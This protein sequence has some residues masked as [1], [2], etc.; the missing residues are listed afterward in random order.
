MVCWLV[1]EFYWFV[2]SF[3]F[4]A[5]FGFWC[6]GFCFGLGLCLVGSWRCLDFGIFGVVVFVLVRLCFYCLVCVMVYLGLCWF[7]LGWLVYRLTM[8]GWLCWLM[9]GV[10]LEYLAVGWVLDW[11]CG[12][13]LTCCAI[14]CFIV[15]FVTWCLLDLCFCLYIGCLRVCCCYSVLLFA[16][17]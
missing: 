2:L 8:F 13:L 14:C 17:V 9:F 6:F 15:G 11:V 5:C 10:Y 1:Y 16:W 7:L 3:V 12:W 4:W